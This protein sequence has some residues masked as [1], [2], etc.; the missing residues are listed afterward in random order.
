MTSS[1]DPS[2]AGLLGHIVGF[3]ESSATPVV[4]VDEA[5]VIT[6]VNA[7]AALLFDYEAGDLM[8]SSVDVLVPDWALPR[9]AADRAD[10]TSRPA[11]RPKG[12]GLDLHARRRDGS[13]V[14]VDISLNVTELADGRRWTVAGVT[15][16]SERIEAQ[17]QVAELS[18]AY[19]TLVHL[20]QAV[21]RAVDVPSLYA[22]TCRIAVEQGATP[23]RSWPCPTR[24]ARSS[25]W[26]ARGGWTST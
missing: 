26:L 6:Y 19:L 5:G 25:S 10:F 14:P 16:I 23:A 24:G 9:H 3:L 2:T 13:E 18:A 12:L 21:I 1:T 22:E 7:G 17:A 4:V 15:D 8:G 11:A 20:N